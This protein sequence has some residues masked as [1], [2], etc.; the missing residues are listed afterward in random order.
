MTR[1]IRI[2]KTNNYILRPPL[3]KKNSMRDDW[4]VINFAVGCTH[5]CV[6]CY[7]D[8]FHKKYSYERVGE[9]VYKKWGQYFA[10]PQNIDEVIEETPWWKWRGKNV[11][12]SS[13]HDPYLPQLLKI[14]EKILRKAIN[15]QINLTIATRSKLVLQHLELLKKGKDR[16]TVMI[17]IPTLN[18]DFSRIIEPRVPTP[19]QRIEIL[20]TLIK[21]G[22]KTGVLM[23]PLFPPNRHNPDVYRDMENL[24]KELSKIGVEVVIAEALHRRG[25]NLYYLREVLGEKIPVNKQVEEELMKIF[26]VVTKKYGVYGEWIPEYIS[27]ETLGAYYMKEKK[28]CC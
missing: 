5:G 26:F 22:I 25:L 4:Y 27:D 12:M 3:I 14:T 28:Y 13:S 20:K 23:A 18:E 24:I 21:N 1:T 6:F 19:R 16:I 2:T 15:Y 8:Y 10:I 7:S 9:I 11:W 17:S